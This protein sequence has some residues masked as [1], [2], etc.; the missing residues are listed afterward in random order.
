MTRDA[1][2]PGVAAP[3]RGVLAYHPRKYKQGT[4]DLYGETVWVCP[5][6]HT[7]IPMR[8]VGRFDDR[9][10][11]A[12]VLYSV[13]PFLLSRDVRRLWEEHLGDGAVWDGEFPAKQKG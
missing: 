5:C 2:I 1:L 12:V 10:D 3:N 13:Q 9:R 4:A 11:R 7:L 6:C 8:F